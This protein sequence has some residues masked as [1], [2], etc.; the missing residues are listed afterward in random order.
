MLE[1]KIIAPRSFG[2]KLPY[3]HLDRAEGRSVTVPTEIPP[4]VNIDF[5]SQTLSPIADA[6]TRVEPSQRIIELLV[7]ST[8]VLYC[9]HLRSLFHHM[10]IRAIESRFEQLSVN[11][12]NEQVNG[13]GVFHKS[14]V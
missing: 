9:L 11:D 4:L 13:G 5:H 14:K 2:F 1:S 6:A 3:F 8:R 10:A 12:E 7:Y